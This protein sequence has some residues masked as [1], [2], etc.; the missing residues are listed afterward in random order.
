[1][2]E[3]HHTPPIPAGKFVLRMLVHAGL[4]LALI[5]ISLLVGIIGYAHY[6]HMPWLDA[7]LNSAMLLG[8]MG[9]VKTAGLSEAGKF[10]AGVYALYAGLV[11]IAV[12]SIIFAPVIHRVL[13]RFHWDEQRPSK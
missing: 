13:H 1:M 3:P 2:Y 12:M 9:P 4:A 8:G 11:F 6:E 7:F 10:F 5:G